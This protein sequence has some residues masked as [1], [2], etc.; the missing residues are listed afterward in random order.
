MR[1]ANVGTQGAKRQ[2]Y[3][4]DSP[5]G[6][7]LKLID[8]NPSMS[9]GDIEETMW[10]EVR[11]RTSVMRAIFEYW[12]ANN[13]RSLDREAEVTE[14]PPKPERKP[15]ERRELDLDL[16]NRVNETIKKAMHKK[17]Q[18]I[19]ME[20]ILPTGRT[21]GETTCK[22][23]K[24]LSPVLSNWLQSVATM[25]PDTNQKIKDAISEEQLKTAYGGE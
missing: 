13:W 19:L 22:E 10:H 16:E 1:N 24:E 2:S 20:M 12:F 15:R 9:E 21:L 25:L 7:L 6:I 4:R 8:K 23:F 5:R 17:A 3:H 14:T 18:T 11:S